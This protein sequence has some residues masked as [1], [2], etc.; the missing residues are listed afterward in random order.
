MLMSVT[1]KLNELLNVGISSE[2]CSAKELTVVALNSCCLLS[3]IYKWLQSHQ[4]KSDTDP[5]KVGEATKIPFIGIN[6]D[7]MQ[8]WPFPSVMNHRRGSF[9]LVPSVMAVI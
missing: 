1:A 6:R 8:L 7:K 4:I 9:S 2:M 5:V 3:F